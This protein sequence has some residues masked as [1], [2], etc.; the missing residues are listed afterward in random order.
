MKKVSKIH[1]EPEKLGKYDLSKGVRGKYAGRV[2]PE[3][4]VIVRNKPA[5]NGRED[6][7]TDKKPRRRVAP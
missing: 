4:E 7:P 1:E 3:T 2:G 6:V 5:D